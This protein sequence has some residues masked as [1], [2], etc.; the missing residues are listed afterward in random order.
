VPLRPRSDR[1]THRREIEERGERNAQEQIVPREAA[2][3]GFLLVAL[4]EA[5]VRVAFRLFRD[6]LGRLLL[7]QDRAYAR[8]G[9]CRD[10]SA[11]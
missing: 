5:L 7:R 10:T 2:G 6:N 9:R 1:P 4:D 8:T 11:R 3:R